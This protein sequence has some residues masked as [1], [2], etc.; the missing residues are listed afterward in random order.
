MITEFNLLRKY[1]SGCS[2]VLHLADSNSIGKKTNL[3]N[4]Q[5]PQFFPT[6]NYLNFLSQFPV[7]RWYRV[8]AA[9]AT[10]PP[11]LQW[12]SAPRPGAPRARPPRCPPRSSR[13]HRATPRSPTWPRRSW[14]TSWT[15]HLTT[16]TERN[17]EL[18][19]HEKGGHQWEQTG[20]KICW[21]WM[22]LAY[23]VWILRCWQQLLTERRCW[24]G[25]R[26]AEGRSTA[27]SCGLV[28]SRSRL[29]SYSW[30]NGKPGRGEV[31][32]WH[33]KMALEV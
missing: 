19:K 7:A 12:L 11:P 20:N 17:L 1:H 8:A 15:R 29:N 30:S 27:G 2:N 3:Q 4:L 14:K 25:R 5:L 6:K 10:D 16:D 24:Y 22:N 26:V 23:L 28:S 9:F 18:V 32:S 33:R 31:S 21:I 13:R